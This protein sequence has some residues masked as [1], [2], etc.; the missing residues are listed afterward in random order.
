MV[1]V[2]KP[3]KLRLHPTAVPPNRSLLRG[4][5]AACSAELGAFDMD[6]DRPKSGSGP[7]HH[8]LVAKIRV[9]SAGALE[10]RI[11]AASSSG[12]PAVIDIANKIVDEA[13][14]N[15]SRMSTKKGGPHTNSG[16]V[17]SPVADAAALRIPLRGLVESIELC[18]VLRQQEE[19][20]D[21][22]LCA[23]ML[24]HFDRFCGS[25]VG[26]FDSSASVSSFAELLRFP[27]GQSVLLHAEF[28][29]CSGVESEGREVTVLVVLRAHVDAIT[30][31]ELLAHTK[32]SA[33]HTKMLPDSTRRLNAKKG[34][35]PASEE[36]EE[37]LKL[38]SLVAF[39]SL[40]HVEDMSAKKV[41]P[42][43]KGRA[44]KKAEDAR[45]GS[46]RLRTE[47]DDDRGAGRGEKSGTI[48]HSPSLMPLCSLPSAVVEASATI[49]AAD[50]TA[51]P[52]LVF[53]PRQGGDDES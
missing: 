35:D 25:T 51:P 49:A 18:G 21:I 34:A 14:S 38:L 30:R 2:N 40:S 53:A 52:L 39:A 50:T 17:G 48:S 7:G 43:G 6:Y 12:A 33:R 16:L 8:Q 4:I 5:R 47:M 9:H 31:E 44:S 46:K 20:G 24:D 10:R 41:V 15:S 11:L 22:V 19:G 27:Q 26:V 1:L 32:I 37:V 13:T 36:A 3:D 28:N 45:S 29:K 23:T 42:E